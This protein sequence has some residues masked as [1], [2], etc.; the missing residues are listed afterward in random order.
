MHMRA[1]SRPVPGGLLAWPA[2]A[3]AA[4]ASKTETG[5]KRILDLR[6]GRQFLAVVRPTVHSSVAI[7][8]YL[9]GDLC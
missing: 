4:G 7:A 1:R 2:A 9:R 6:A 8:M 3:A 5:A